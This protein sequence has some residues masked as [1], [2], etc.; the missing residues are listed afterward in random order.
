MLSPEQINEL[1]RLDDDALVDAR[2]AAAVVGLQYQ[3]LN[4]Y[5]CVSPERGPA[6]R[7]VGSKAIRYRMGDLRAYVA[8]RLEG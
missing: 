3:T 5:R 6:F 2:E 1:L 7:R 8:A 4:W